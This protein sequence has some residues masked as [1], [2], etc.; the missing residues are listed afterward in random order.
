MHGDCQCHTRLSLRRVF[1]PPAAATHSRHCWSCTPP[2]VHNP[3]ADDDP[4]K[5][6]RFASGLHLPYRLRMKPFRCRF[7]TNAA[8]PI[9]LHLASTR[10]RKPFRKYF[11]PGLHNTD[12]D[13]P[14]WTKEFSPHNQPNICAKLQP[15]FG[16]LTCCE[17]PSSE[18]RPPLIRSAVRGRLRD[19]IDSNPAIAPRVRM[20]I[21]RQLAPCTYGRS[22][23]LSSIFD[24]DC[25]P[26]KKVENKTLDRNDL[27]P[28]EKTEQM[29]TPTRSVFSLALSHALN[30]LLHFTLAAAPV[31]VCGSDG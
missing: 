6:N 27:A 30:S 11:P 23:T 2:L 26:E 4:T 13:L 10:P 21:G 29:T 20:K 5:M 25:R 14:Q 19:E 18:R 1:P 22:I 28:S 12:R 24:S 17:L 8:N 15:S 16:T 31:V 3:T 9:I 7:P